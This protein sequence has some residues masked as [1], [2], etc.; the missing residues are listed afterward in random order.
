[1]GTLLVPLGYCFEPFFYTGT[2][3]VPLKKRGTKTV[4]PKKGGTKTAPNPNPN[5]TRLEHSLPIQP[6]N[7]N[8]TPKG[9]ILR[10]AK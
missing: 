1:M 5:P 6:P 7:L 4:P 9:T 2:K 3:V 8:N 10:T